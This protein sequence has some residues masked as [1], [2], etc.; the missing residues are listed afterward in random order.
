MKKLS[1]Y[2]FLV[3]MVCSVSFAEKIY[4]QCSRKTIVD[5]S[6]SMFT[7]LSNKL[8]MFDDEKIELHLLSHQFFE[9][10]D[11][12]GKTVN[13]IA[14]ELSRSLEEGESVEKKYKVDDTYYYFH[15]GNTDQAIKHNLTN[16]IKKEYVIAQL[17]KINLDLT[18]KLFFHVIVPKGT[19][20]EYDRTRIEESKTIEKCKIVQPKL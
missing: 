14:P 17:N 3:L 7:A 9:I 20:L 5:S 19:S 4:L 18:R 6:I 16:D 11:Y 13:K 2:V 8:Y 15:G 12:K 1:L 10:T